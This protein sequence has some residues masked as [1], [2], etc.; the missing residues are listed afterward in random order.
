MTRQMLKIQQ[1]ALLLLDAGF[2]YL[3]VARLFGMTE[4]QV[5]NLCRRNDESENGQQPAECDSAKLQLR[6]LPTQSGPIAF[7]FCG[8][9]RL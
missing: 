7:R 9:D 5:R 6:S 3:E 2:D 4:G 1:A 8:K